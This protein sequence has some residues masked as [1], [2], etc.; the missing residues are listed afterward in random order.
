M[1]LYY[2]DFLDVFFLCKWVDI[3]CFDE[4]Y[5]LGVQFYVGVFFENLDYIVDVVVIG[6]L[7][8]LEVVCIYVESIGCLVSLVI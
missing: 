3:I 2:G 5:N 8:F 7:R 4:V 6:V 1:K